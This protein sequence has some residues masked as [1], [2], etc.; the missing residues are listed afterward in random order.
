MTRFHG[1]I[2]AT[3]LLGMTLI[4]A[5]PAFGKLHVSPLGLVASN[6]TCD[7]GKQGSYTYMA[8][9][10]GAAPNMRYTL[11]TGNQ[12][13][14]GGQVCATA[15]ST[16][17]AVTCN[18]NGVCSTT[19]NACVATAAAAGQWLKVLGSDGGWQQVGALAP[20]KCL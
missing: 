7:S 2:A 11:H 4:A 20:S 6:A 15:L 16:G 19:V 9:W 12:C 18:A 10:Q 14:I 17:C 8:R 13:R 3:V 5:L 1:L